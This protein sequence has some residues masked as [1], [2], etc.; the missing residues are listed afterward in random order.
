LKSDE[1]T[2]KIEDDKDNFF[3][4]SSSDDSFGEKTKPLIQGY[5]RKVKRKNTIVSSLIKSN[6]PLFDEQ[7]IEHIDEENSSAGASHDQEMYVGSSYM[8]VNK[9]TG[10]GQLENGK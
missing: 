4:D 3:I 1:P 8:E 5:K 9:S 2:A 7:I 6:Q 10:M